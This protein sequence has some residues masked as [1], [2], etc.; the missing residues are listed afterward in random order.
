M[1]MPLPHLGMTSWPFQLLSARVIASG[2]KETD[3][4][5]LGSDV[6]DTSN[7]VETSQ[8]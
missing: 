2:S 4:E 6:H 7:D 5:P 8:R 3:K 1:T